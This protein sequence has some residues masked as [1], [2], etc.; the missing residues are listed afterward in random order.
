MDN[1]TR[2]DIRLDGYDYSRSGAYFVTVCTKNMQHF[3]WEYPNRYIALTDTNKPNVGAHSVRPTNDRKI[4]LSEYG[5][6][7][8]CSFRI[9]S[10]HYP[11]VFFDR[12][13]IMPNH[14]HA[15]IRIENREIAG[16]IGGRTEC[17]PTLSLIVKNLKENVTREIG[18]S[19]W[20]KSF[21]DRIIR[22]E[23]EYRA[24]WQYI[25]NNPTNWESDEY[26][27]ENN[28]KER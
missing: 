25:E 12:Y 26:F 3:F 7:V 20:Q 21:Y 5:K 9:V 13:V 15:I 18:F 27:S 22:N 2:K 14:I 1:P 16:M 19:V 10:E 24:Y 4:H 23:H 17:A 8:K 6:A 11:N 28:S